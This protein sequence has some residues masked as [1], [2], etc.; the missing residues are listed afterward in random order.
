MILSCD[1]YIPLSVPL[2]IR[3]LC[4][5]TT[6]AGRDVLASI[7]ATMEKIKQ[8]AKGKIQHAIRLGIL[9]RPKT[10]S[11]CGKIPPPAKD[12]RS[13]IHGHHTDYSKPLQVVW[14][15]VNCHRSETPQPTG[16]HH[17]RA[18]LTLNEVRDIFNFKPVRGCN[19]IL[20]K[21]FKVSQSVISEIRNRK[22]WATAMKESGL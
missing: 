14:I 2:G 7:T 1:S 22:L 16:E 4:F 8:Q 3:P 10:C 6:V 17:G 21:T 15:C 5:R 9:V 18:K 20:A 12:G 19:A 13:Q 11:K